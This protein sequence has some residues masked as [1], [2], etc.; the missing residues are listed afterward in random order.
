MRRGLAGALALFAC[1]VPTACADDGPRQTADAAVGPADTSPAAGT[2]DLTQSSGATVIV[3]SID[4]TF[5]PEVL[6]VAAGTEVVWQNRGRNEHDILSDVG[7][8]VA[9]ADFQPGDEYRYVFLEPGEYP[10][11]CTIHGTDTVG[12]I[13]TVV[14]TAAA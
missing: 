3:Q 9:A 6:E 7:F 5:R 2:E 12:M 11:W 10:Y 1:A 4:N 13:G 8:G 14:V